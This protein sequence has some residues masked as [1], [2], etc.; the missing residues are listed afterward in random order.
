MY[1]L[2]RLS[3]PSIDYV[4]QVVSLNQNRSLIFALALAYCL[5]KD[6][7]LTS[8]PVEEVGI[9]FRNNFKIPLSRVIGSINEVCPMNTSDVEKFSLQFFKQRI[10]ALFPAAT[11]IMVRKGKGVV[12][13]FGI[14]MNFSDEELV[15]IDSDPEAFMNHVAKLNVLI[16]EIT[17]SSNWISQP[18]D[19]QVAK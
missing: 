3:K 13:L 5:T 19:H 18:E 4:Q 10:C 7:A 2:S 1:Y 16:A 9:Y 17:K 6:I 11:P 12:D 8:A 14:N 15:A